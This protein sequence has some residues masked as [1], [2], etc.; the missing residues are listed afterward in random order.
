[1]FNKLALANLLLPKVQVSQSLQLAQL[2]Q[3][4]K[5]EL[6]IQLAL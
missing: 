1:M 3:L 6:G 2:P 5:Q 4:Q